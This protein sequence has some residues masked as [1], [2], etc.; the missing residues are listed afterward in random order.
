MEAHDA[1]ACLM[2]MYDQIPA[3]E[4]IEFGRFWQR[5]NRLSLSDWAS[6]DVTGTVSVPTNTHWCN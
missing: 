1:V 3:S 5:P 6:G 4:R 2:Q